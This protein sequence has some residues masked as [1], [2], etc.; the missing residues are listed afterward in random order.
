MQASSAEQGAVIVEIVAAVR[1]VDYWRAGVLM[2]RFVRDADLAALAAL[3]GAL[4]EDAAV[5][6]RL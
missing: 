1:N 4:N 6:Q 5:E 2:E 3:R